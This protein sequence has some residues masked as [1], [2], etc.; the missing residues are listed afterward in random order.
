MSLADF[1]G[2]GRQTASQPI[3][4]VV[5]SEPFEKKLTKDL[6]GLAVY[7]RANGNII[8]TSVY[9]QV[10]RIDDVLRPLLVY[11][12]ANGCSPEQEHL[13]T[14]MITDY[15]PTPLKTF[16]SLPRADRA[17]NGNPARLLKEQFD[18]MLEKVYDLSELVRR[19]ALSELAMHADFIDDR[20]SGA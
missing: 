3:V 11:I 14:S 7:M 5:Q 8:P 12:T 16:I 20:F 15:I 18:T 4:P 19:G 1:F 2:V 17:D 9:S 10:R 6:D 13:L